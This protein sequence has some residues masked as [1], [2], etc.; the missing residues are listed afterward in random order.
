MR[1]VA[2]IAVLLAASLAGAASRSAT[3]AGPCLLSTFRI[4]LGSGVSEATGQHTITLRLVNRGARA[5]V[6]FGYPV[7]GAYAAH[8]RIPFAVTHG[9]DQMVTARRPTRVL[10]RPR[11]AAFVALNHNRCDRGD[12]RT[13]TRLRIGTSGSARTVRLTAARLDYC[14]KGDPGSTVAV[15]PFE[16]TLR[17]TLRSG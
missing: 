8:G 13:A 5:C 7:I 14:G 4:R 17:A 15:S 16:P 2:P 1:R 12:L 6:L 9:G 3:A 10:V 11:G